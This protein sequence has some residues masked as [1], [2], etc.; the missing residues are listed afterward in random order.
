MP[1]ISKRIDK[2]RTV[3]DLPLAVGFGN[4]NVEHV[5]SVHKVADAAIIGSALVRRLDE[6]KDPVT[7]ATQFLKEILQ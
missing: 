4:S 1:D 6:A 2:I 7:S 5:K 3:T